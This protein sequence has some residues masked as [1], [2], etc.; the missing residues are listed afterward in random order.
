MNVKAA[1]STIVYSLAA[2]TSQA[3]ECAVTYPLCSERS[4]LCPHNMC[5]NPD[6][7]C[8]SQGD[9][10]LDIRWNRD[11]CVDPANACGTGYCG[12][13]I[14][15]WFDIKFLLYLVHSSRGTW[16]HCWLEGTPPYFTDCYC[17]NG[18]CIAL[19]NQDTAATTTFATTTST[20]I[21]EYPET[22]TTSTTRYITQPPSDV[23]TTVTSTGKSSLMPSNAPSESYRPTQEDDT[24]DGRIVL[25]R[26][27][28][29][30]RFIY[31]A[32]SLITPWFDSML[33]I[34]LLCIDLTN[35][36]M[37]SKV[38]AGVK[39]TKYTRDPSH[40]ISRAL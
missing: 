5:T 17:E 37:G 28:G 10:C 26:N 2:I 32:I 30:L 31:F 15:W 12:K 34:C 8:N 21:S 14:C 11:F 20:L 6:G 35:W 36:C 9:G 23:T 22:S 1:A 38:D 29:L 7:K 40:C 24:S 18:T 39:P 25:K 16:F 33:A 13:R 19:E 27:L 3:A 4:T